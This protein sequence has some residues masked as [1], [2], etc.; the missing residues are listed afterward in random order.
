MAD[1]VTITKEHIDELCRKYDLVFNSI[2]P[3]TYKFFIKS[4]L[5]NPKGWIEHLE[6]GYFNSFVELR[7]T[8][9]KSVFYI[10]EQSKWPKKEDNWNYYMFD[11]FCS[12]V[13]LS[14]NLKEFDLWIEKTVEYVH[15]LPLIERQRKIELGLKEINKD[16]V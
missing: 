8:K 3:R 10:V 6:G 5:F 12:S 11:Y 7:P 15:R 13:P 2:H 4:P 14:K 1:Y 9:D 16:F